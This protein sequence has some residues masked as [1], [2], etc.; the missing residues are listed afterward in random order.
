MGMYETEALDNI[1]HQIKEQQRDTRELAD[2]FYKQFDKAIS[3]ARDA[4]EQR[5]Q[6]MKDLTE[7][8]RI[9]NEQK[10]IENAMR[11]LEFNL[12]NNQFGDKTAEMQ[13]VY[14]SLSTR[15]ID[16]AK[17][18]VRDKSATKTSQRGTEFDD[19]LHTETA[20]VLDVQLE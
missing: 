14:K 6:M 1:K 18:F 20:P 12:E 9:G 19:M 16:Q 5:Y 4:N 2:D 15:V 10:L 7:Q 11:T 3:E 17:E 13:E 8:M